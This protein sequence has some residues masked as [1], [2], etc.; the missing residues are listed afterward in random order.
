VFVEADGRV[1]VAPA[2]RCSHA[3]RVLFL[4]IVGWQP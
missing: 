1:S 4:H 3:E 2:A